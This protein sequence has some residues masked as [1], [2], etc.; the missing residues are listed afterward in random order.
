MPAN[1]KRLE[2]LYLSTTEI[3]PA[4]FDMKMFCNGNCGTPQCIFGH[5]AARKDLQDAFRITQS[6][7]FSEFDIVE[8]V[9]GELFDTRD[10]CA[11][12]GIT[13]QEYLALFSGEG[14]DGARTPAEAA[15]YILKFIARK[16]SQQ[17]AE[18]AT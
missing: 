6:Y 16:E 1:I 8:T 3:R 13:K 5:Y 7:A 14:C 10:V 9:H 15:A 2:A 4:Q 12:F 11:H 17:A 18:V